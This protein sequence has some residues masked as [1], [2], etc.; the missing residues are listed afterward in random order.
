MWLMV[1]IT[2]H[3]T[4][5]QNRKAITSYVFE[6]T[7]VFDRPDSTP[8]APPIGVF[9]NKS[10]FRCIFF[11]LG[12]VVHQLL[13]SSCW[14]SKLRWWYIHIRLTAILLQQL[15]LFELFQFVFAYLEYLP[16]HNSISSIAQW[17]ELHYIKLNFVHHHF[18]TSLF[19]LLYL[20]V[21]PSKFVHSNC[22]TNID[23]LWIQLQPA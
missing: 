3:S 11:C 16:P 2:N 18:D 6:M 20:P 15:G 14:I 7:W 21:K 17:V 9:P 8:D 5:N 13:K 19:D 22:Q 1:G 23:F 12:K 10:F 4:T